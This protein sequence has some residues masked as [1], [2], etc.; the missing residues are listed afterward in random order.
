MNSLETCTPSSTPPQRP[1]RH[2]SRVVLLVLAALALMA[3]M[4]MVIPMVA[5]NVGATVAD[6]LRT[7]LGPGPVAALESA[8]FRMQDEYNRLRYRLTGGQPQI[9]WAN[10]TPLPYTPAPAQ[11][12]PSTPAMPTLIPT[13]TPSPTPAAIPTSI[14]GPTTQATRGSLTTRPGRTLY[15]TLTRKERTRLAQV[16]PTP[17]PTTRL[18]PSASATATSLPASNALPTVQPTP[19]AQINVVNASPVAG[20]GWQAF[21]MLIA[22]SPVMARASVNPDA[23]RPYAEAALVRIDLAQ[24]QLQLVPGTAEP[25]AAKGA[26]AFARPGKIP[27][28]DQVAGKLLAAFNGGFRTIHGAYGMMVNGVTILPPQD[29]MATLAFYRDG[30]VRIGAWGRDMSLSPDILAY[31]QNCPLLLDAGELS[32][33]VVSGSRK[34]W[35]YTISNLDT[36]WRSG[37]GISRDG[38]FLIYAVGNSLTVDSLARAL[39]A[40]GA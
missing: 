13:E 36:T 38:R 4:L 3:A 33:S 28:T 1:T 20:N 5:P 40:G 16:T 2:R 19:E 24:V 21:D 14:L 29:G 34:E 9:A 6:V 15:P 30:S 8:S 27:T 17:F 18:G 37:L 12:Q 7:V 10:K 39:Q 35:G 31:R 11:P 32:P 23:A 25:V 26:P 22:G